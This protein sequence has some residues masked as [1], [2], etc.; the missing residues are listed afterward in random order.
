MV[1]DGKTKKCSN[2]NTKNEWNA[3]KHQWTIV[4]KL[5]YS[6][7][8]LCETALPALI[9]H[10]L[11]EFWHN[12]YTFELVHN[13]NL[14]IAIRIFMSTLHCYAEHF[15]VTLTTVMARSGYRVGSAEKV[16]L[17]FLPDLPSP[18]SMACRPEYGH[19]TTVKWREYT[20]IHHEAWIGRE[21]YYQG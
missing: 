4:I 1:A 5:V 9:T 15:P 18:A 16:I 8:N 2:F 6:R 11:G 20:S 17:T 14:D 19:C 13:G 7:Q 21:N 3:Q 12:Y 10:H